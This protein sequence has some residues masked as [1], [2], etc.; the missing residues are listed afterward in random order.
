LSI[1]WFHSCI[2]KERIYATIYILFSAK[3]KIERK[4]L[5]VGPKIDLMDITKILKKAFERKKMYKRKK[6]NK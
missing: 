3:R 2:F 1:I 4:K 6:G 5:I